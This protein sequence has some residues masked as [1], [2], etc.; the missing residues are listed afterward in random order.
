M[1]TRNS[2]EQQTSTKPHC[3]KIESFCLSTLHQRMKK[4]PTTIRHYET[5]HKRWLPTKKPHKHHQHKHNRIEHQT[6]SNQAEDEKKYNNDEDIDYAYKN[7]NDSDELFL[8]NEDDD[9]QY[10]PYGHVD[11]TEGLKDNTVCDWIIPVGECVGSCPVMS[12]SQVLLF[13]HSC[14]Y[15]FISFEDFRIELKFPSVL[16][17]LSPSLNACQNASLV[18]IY[19][20]Y[21]ASESLVEKFCVVK[22][23]S[24]NETNGNTINFISKGS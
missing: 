12:P 14:T 17:Q 16:L 3:I 2:A 11:R 7:A 19:D 9:E 10:L 5:R 8:N 24:D 21:E 22:L 13:N 15:L 23:D 6:K 18:E 4:Q 20:G 1:L